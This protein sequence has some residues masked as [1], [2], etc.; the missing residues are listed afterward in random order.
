MR[1]VVDG[2]RKT[3][4]RW[5]LAVGLAVALPVSASA[6][7]LKIGLS[8]EPSSIDPHYHNLTPNNG[9]LSHI[10]E[11]LIANAPDNS[12]IP[13]LAQSWKTLDEKTWEFRLRPNVQW[14]DGSPFTVDDVIF[15]FERA[16][17]VPNS[18]SSFASSVKGKTLKKVDDLT[19]LIT[20]EQPAPLVPSEVSNLLMISRK[21]GTGAKTEDFNSGKAA[22]GTGP[23]KLVARV[24]GDRIELA[25]NDAHWGGKPKWP[26]LTFKPISSPPARVA[27]LLAGDVDMIE[28]VPTAD[29]ERLKKDP[30]VEISQG[31]SRR[32]IYFHMDQ[33]RETTPFIKAKDGTAIKNPLKDQRV[34]LA[35]SKALNREAIVSRVM[36]GVAIPAGQLLDT[37][38]FGTSKT[39]K[40]TAY[41]PEGAKKLLAEA[42]FPA[43]FKMTLHGP[44]GRYTN[45]VKI[46]EAAAQ[47]FTRVGIETSV[48]TIPPAVFFTRAST[49]A[50]G[51]PEFSFIL[52]GWGSD[53]GET[54]SP[55]KS[56][57]GTFDRDKGRG[58]ANRGRYSNPTLDALVDEALATVDDAK[59]GAI[60]AKASELAMLDTGLIP[61]HYQINTW[62]TRKGLK[63]TARADEYTLAVSLSGQ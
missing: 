22:I 34:R 38:F 31:V 24:P 2:R 1:G 18:P 19:F 11:R 54:S 17:A 61:S 44:A 55:L 49:G 43:G 59:R 6:Q 52:V 46:A 26:T 57:L 41:D 7:G 42:G 37:S 62:A 27:A 4:R 21:H 23:Y 13:G 58:T 25:A 8:A 30:K 5:L 63:Y 39:L 16:P 10:F 33:F 51:E 15:T 12:L 20:T 56:L 36:E 32:V 47:M 3:T 50:A 29:I 9:I 28:D 48:E 45:D 35:L 53:T 40:P 60:L 14:H